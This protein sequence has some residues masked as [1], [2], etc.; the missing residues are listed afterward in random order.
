MIAT[1]R[2][3]V[4]AVGVVVVAEVAAAAA[5]LSDQKTVC[6]QGKA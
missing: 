3:Q 1:R 4:I 2:P 5:S 6:M